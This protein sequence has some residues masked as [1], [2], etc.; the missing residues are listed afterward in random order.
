MPLDSVQFM[1]VTI[2]PFRDKENYYYISPFNGKLYKVDNDVFRKNNIDEKLKKALYVVD[3]PFSY[4]AL[5]PENYCTHIDAENYK[6][7]CLY[8]NLLLKIGNEHFYLSRIY[9]S[10]RSYLF[11]SSVDAFDAISKIEKQKEYKN[12]LC[13]QRSLLVIKTSKSFRNNG[14]LF[15]GASF[16]SGK[17]HAWIIENGFQPDR[18]DRNWIMYRPLLAIYY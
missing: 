4:E 9:A 7:I 18:L 3:N 15:I 12:E 1:K 13:L 10:F 8:H 11:N 6:K 5:H 17:M 14:V 2:L 16:P